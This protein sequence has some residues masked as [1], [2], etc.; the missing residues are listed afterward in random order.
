[1]ADA[2]TLCPDFNDRPLVSDDGERSTRYLRIA[3]SSLTVFTISIYINRWAGGRAHDQLLCFPFQGQDL[4]SRPG[5][6]SGSLSR[7]G[8]W[9]HRRWT[10]GQESLVYL[11]KKSVRMI[12]TRTAAS[13]ILCCCFLSAGLQDSLAR[14]ALHDCAVINNDVLHTKTLFS[15]MLLS[16]PFSPYSLSPLVFS[17]S[18]SCPQD[19]K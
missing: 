5:L 19:D 4:N 6:D 7:S 9:F 12:C 11:F 2:R 15:R 16:S 1:L 14:R 17:F 3:I 13:L 8:L 18:H 10:R